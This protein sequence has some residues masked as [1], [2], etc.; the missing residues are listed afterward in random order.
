[1]EIGLSASE[2]RNGGFPFGVDHPVV[3]FRPSLSVTGEA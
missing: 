3:L 2:D 1:M